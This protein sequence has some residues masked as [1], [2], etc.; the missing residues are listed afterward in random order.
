MKYFPSPRLLATVKI[1]IIAK[2]AALI[3]LE[4]LIVVS[5]C[6][7]LFVLCEYIEYVVE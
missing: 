2:D 3:Y 5:V 4:T 7:V 1:D 6:R